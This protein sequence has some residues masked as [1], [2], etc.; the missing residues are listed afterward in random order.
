MIPHGGIVHQFILKT[1]ATTGRSPTLEDIQQE[2][3]LSSIG[4]ADKLVADLERLGAIHRNPGDREITHAYPFSNEP[5]PHHVQLAD[6]PRVYAMCALD[7]LGIPFM[8]KQDATIHSVCA[9]CAGE[10]QIQIQSERITTY[11]SERIVIWYPHV[12]EEC[13]AAVDLCHQLNFFCSVDHL[14]RWNGEHPEKRG[15]LLTLEQALEGGRRTFE[16]LL[17]EPDR[18]CS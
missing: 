3:K 10:I 13:V 5:T 12:Q 7:A 16:T 4:E 1:F 17:Q 6:G 15:H 8:L 11:S 2:F 14:E 18:C 9:Q